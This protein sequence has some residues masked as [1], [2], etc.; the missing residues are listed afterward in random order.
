VKIS[1][2]PPIIREI[3]GRWFVVITDGDGSQHGAQVGEWF[4]AQ[5]VTR[6]VLPKLVLTALNDPNQPTL[7]GIG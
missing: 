1:Q 6:V 5:F 4:A 7:P 3:D 2:S